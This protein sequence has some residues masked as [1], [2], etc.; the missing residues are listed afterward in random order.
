M[1]RVQVPL[2][3]REQLNNIMGWIHVVL[4]QEHHIVL[5]IT[6]MEHVTLHHAVL[7]Q[8]I[9]LAITRMERVLKKPVVLGLF[10]T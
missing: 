3:V 5:A 10:P 8:L 4:H 6:R 1:E 7:E 2:V 9:V